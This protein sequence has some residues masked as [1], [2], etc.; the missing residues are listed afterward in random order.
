[1]TKSTK[2]P[3]TTRA[4]QA[5]AVSAP[6]SKLAMLVGL[7]SRPEGARLDEMTAAT[8]WQVHSVRGAMAGSLKKKGL[9]ITSAKTDDGRVYRV[10]T[11][12]SA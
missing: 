8:G 12:P 6:P 2:T 7:L 1:M 5:P 9:S 3:K 10:A 4:A 11:E